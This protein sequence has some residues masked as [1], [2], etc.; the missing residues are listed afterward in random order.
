MAARAAT[1]A[2]CP[3]ADEHP[4]E[5]HRAGRNVEVDGHRRWVNRSEREPAR[6]E[7]RQEAHP[8]ANL[9][10]MRQEETAHDAADTGDAS[11]EDEQDRRGEPDQNPAEQRLQRR[12][13][14]GY[15]STPAA[16]SARYEAKPP[17]RLPTR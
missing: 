13:V 1:P 7:A 8:P 17:E 4:C 16:T 10:M 14:S 2:T 15:G 9:P 3:E 11:V 6:H 5:E 12:K